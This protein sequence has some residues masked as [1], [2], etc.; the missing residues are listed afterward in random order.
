MCKI[1]DLCKRIHQKGRE[2]EEKKLED[3]FNFKKMNSWFRS[4]MFLKDENFLKKYTQTQSNNVC[5]GR[6]EK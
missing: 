5:H 6:S 2:P 4:T 3:E 1:R